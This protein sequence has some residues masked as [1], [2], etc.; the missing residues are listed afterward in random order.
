MALAD[1][2]HIAVD[3]LVAVGIKVGEPPPTPSLGRSWESRPGGIWVLRRTFSGNIDQAV[4]D[5]DVLFGTDAVDP[6][7]QWA[8]MRSSLQLS[9]PPTVPVTRLSVA[10][11]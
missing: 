8:L 11:S 3:D 2:E 7:P 9:D 1:E 6:R 4:T 5:I 10:Q